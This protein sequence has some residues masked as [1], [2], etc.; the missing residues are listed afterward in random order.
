[1]TLRCINTDGQAIQL[2]GTV[3]KESRE[4][5]GLRDPEAGEGLRYTFKTV[6]Q[7]PAGTHRIIVALPNKDIAVEREF[8]LAE[9]SKNYLQLEPNYYRSRAK[10]KHNVVATS[11]TEGIQ[12]F[13]V[14][15]NGKEL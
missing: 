2:K 10:Q 8:V 11:F 4:P 13:T 12:S 14:K 9:G 1:M 7:L 6:V 5:R 3:I 15:F